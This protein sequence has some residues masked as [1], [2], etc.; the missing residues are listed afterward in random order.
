[1][2]RQFP[3]ANIEVDT[4]YFQGPVSALCMDN[5]VY[6]LILGN[7]YQVCEIQQI[8]IQV[9]ARWKEFLHRKGFA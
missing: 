8:Q 9:G 2:A 7:I 4:L 5:P 3:I 6:D 1:M